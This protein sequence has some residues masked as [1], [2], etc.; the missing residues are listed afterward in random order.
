MRLLSGLGGGGLLSGCLHAFA[1]GSAQHAV[2]G[3]S[4]GLGG[5]GRKHARGNQGA[6][7]IHGLD[8]GGAH[9]G[10][11]LA[12]T[13]TG[14]TGCRTQNLCGFR[15]LLG[16]SGLQGPLSV[17]GIGPSRL[18]GVLRGKV[19]RGAALPRGAGTLRGLGYLSLRSTGR[20]AGVRG[21]EAQR[22][23]RAHGVRRA[24]GDL[25]A[26]RLGLL[27]LGFQGAGLRAGGLRL[28][29]LYGLGSLHLGRCGSRNHGR[30]GL[31]PGFLRGTIR[32]GLCIA[33]NLNAGNRK[34]CIRE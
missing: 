9:R 32:N 30:N 17:T 11:N 13:A 31:A 26:R 24:G 14:R 19:L 23:I 34:I 7:T 10:N 1:R 2:A 33:G 15:R 16:G 12:A 22:H 20:R 6:A 3:G 28:N 18:G 27:G 8:D 4:G 25:G 29:R 21:A 5:A